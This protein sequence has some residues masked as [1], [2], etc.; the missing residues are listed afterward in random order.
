[1]KE[2]P[3]F[4]APITDDD[5]SE[6]RKDPD[7]TFGNKEWRIES[8][9]NQ[10]SRRS[11][12]ST[13]IDENHHVLSEFD[14]DI[15]SMVV[16]HARMADIDGDGRISRDE[17]VLGAANMAKDVKKAARKEKNLKRTAGGLTFFTV[18]GLLLNFGLIYVV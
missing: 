12:A 6:T 10:T 9:G 11:F 4:T 7:V 8:F 2:G 5:N 16:K 18:F 13:G 15:K 3:K 17:Y 1:M 14:S